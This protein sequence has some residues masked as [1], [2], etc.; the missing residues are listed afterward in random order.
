MVHV[1]CILKNSRKN[2]ELGYISISQP[3]LKKENHLKINKGGIVFLPLAG[4]FG[5]FSR[6]IHIY[7]TNTVQKRNRK[8]FFK[9]V[10]RFSVYS[11][12]ESNPHSRKNWI[13]NPAR[14]PIPPLEQARTAN[15]KNNPIYHIF[16]CF[17]SMEI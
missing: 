17:I 16:T 8:T 2:V 9:K 1:W 6:L 12:W 3:T 7:R 15:V 13:L 14:L 5:V 11:R 10:M 4:I